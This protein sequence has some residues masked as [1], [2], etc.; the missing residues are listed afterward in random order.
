MRVVYVTMSVRDFLDFSC[1]P[2]ESLGAYCVE[3]DGLVGCCVCVPFVYPGPWLA[4]AQGQLKRCLLACLLVGLLLSTL[5][6]LLLATSRLLVVHLF[7]P[8]FKFPT[9]P[10]ICIVILYDNPYGAYGRSITIHR[11]TDFNCSAASAPLL[12]YL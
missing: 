2:E 1:M 3:G 12:S 4:A 9:L 10:R 6:S 11:T 8:L 5:A 7:P